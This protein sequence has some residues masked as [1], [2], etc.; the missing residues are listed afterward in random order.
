[1]PHLNIDPNTAYRSIP[2]IACIVLALLIAACSRSGGGT[3]P[4]SDDG[5]PPPPVAAT[6]ARSFGGPGT[7]SLTDVE[8][9]ESGQIWIAATFGT[10]G[11]SDTEHQRAWVANLDSAGDVSFE[12]SPQAAET[13]FEEKFRVSRFNGDN[14]AVFAGRVQSRTQGDNVVMQRQRSDGTVEWT[15]QLDGGPWEPQTGRE[16]AASRMYSNDHVMA[17]LGDEFAGWYVVAD[18][19]AS[20]TEGPGLP[21]VIDRSVVVWRIS[22]NGQTV[23]R[24]RVALFDAD[25]GLED[26]GTSLMAATTFVEGGQLKLAMMLRTALRFAAGEGRVRFFEVDSAGVVTRGA[27]FEEPSIG[28]QG[29]LQPG[30]GSVLRGLLLP[31]S[32]PVDGQI[33]PVQANAFL[34]EV[35]RRTEDDV[36]KSELHKLDRSG[37][38]VWR[39]SVDIDLFGDIGTRAEALAQTI[40]VN[41]TS[42]VPELWAVGEAFSGPHAWRYDVDGNLNRICDLR[43]DFPGARRIIA[44]DTINGPPPGEDLRLLIEKDLEGP[45]EL[46]QVE[47]DGDCNLSNEIRF[48]VPRWTVFDRFR[49]AVADGTL[50]TLVVREQADRVTLLVPPTEQEIEAGDNTGEVLE[51]YFAVSDAG[52]ASA[53]ERIVD[54]AVH[55]DPDGRQSVVMAEISGRL[56]FMDGSGAVTR[57]V[58]LDIDGSDPSARTEFGRVAYLTYDA[59]GRAGFLRESFIDQDFYWIETDGTAVRPDIDEEQYWQTDDAV[60]CNECFVYPIAV[61]RSADGSLMSLGTGEVFLPTGK[62]ADVPFLLTWSGD[63]TAVLRRVSDS[64]LLRT[65]DLDEADLERRM[66]LDSLQVGEDEVLLI[67][68]GTAIDMPVSDADLAGGIGLQLA[69]F[70]AEANTRWQY[71]IEGLAV[72]SAVLAHDGGVLLLVAVTGEDRDFDSRDDVAEGEQQDFGLLKL[73]A[74]GRTQWLRVY[75]AGDIDVPLKLG[76][77]TDDTYLVAAASYSVDAVTPASRDVW[78]LKVGIDGR[79][80]AD[81][82]G[83]ESCQAGLDERSG[84]A[85]FDAFQRALQGERQ[86]LAPLGEPEVLTYT[87]NPVDMVELAPLQSSLQSTNT[88]R[89]CVGGATNIQEDPFVQPQTLSIAV[90][91]QGSVTSNPSGLSCPTTCS[92]NYVPETEITLRAMPAPGWAFD[93]WSGDPDCADGVIQSD[94]ARVECT[95]TFSELPSLVGA[96]TVTIDDGGAGANNVVTSMPAGI[97]CPTACAAEFA[98]GEEVMLLPA[99]DVGWQFVGWSG[100]FDCEDGQV[101]ILEGAQGLSCTAIFRQSDDTSTLTLTVNGSGEVFSSEMND[102]GMPL[103]DCL[104]SSEPSVTCEVE[105]TTPRELNLIPTPFNG[106]TDVVWTGCDFDF[107]LEGCR[108]NMEGDRTVTAS[109]Q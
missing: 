89:Q 4:A 97:A 69:H 54:I 82:G 107:G 13:F 58:Q 47:M 80:A 94:A 60:A 96:L 10:D 76:R 39:Q 15:I 7:E 91:G 103:V 65:W 5:E 44:V 56:R 46:I 62:F 53:E 92:A 93:G 109:F 32:D 68:G 59:Q 17:V 24:Q 81:Q 105:I 2:G 9:D 8:V 40:A 14:T 36:L 88:A 55:A 19:A 75:G 18:S 11:D 23:F 28:K 42:V 66:V 106:N 83:A 52:G 37:N 72:R 101:T 71:D 6:F 22:P 26:S 16:Y 51:R 64:L 87:A 45:S 29:N 49:W 57:Y 86:P 48:V 1:M 78:V 43:E 98:V 31:I 61:G 50:E 3:P 104:V 85:L 95:A 102:M 41:G 77:G 84:E 70:G 90:I 108:L 30:T 12:L 20:V 73:D 35:W 67:A 27:S 25:G 74:R 79:I 63:G 21:P 100:D 38:E 34:Y 99:E 33:N